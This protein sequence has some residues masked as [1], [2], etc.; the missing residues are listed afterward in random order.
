LDLSETLL[1]KKLLF[2]CEGEDFGQAQLAS[3]LDGGADQGSAD[4]TA[5]EIVLYGQ[6]FDLRQIG[7]DY[8]KG[9][10][11]DDLAVNGVKFEIT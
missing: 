1:L 8:L 11:A 7:P 2:E 4:T 10:A 5:L 6:G 9:A 3:F